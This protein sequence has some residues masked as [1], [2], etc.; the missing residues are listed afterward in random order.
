LLREHSRK[1]DI[2]SRWGGEE[3]VILL[4]DTNLHGALVV[5]EKI[6]KSVEDAV[7][8]LE[9]KQALKFTMSLGISQV[10]NQKDDDIEV[11]IHKADEALYEA[12]K[13]GRNRIHT[14]INNE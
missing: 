2:I 11:S 8:Y 9:D 10:D 12:K 13:N 5:A 7:I 4:V 3:F 1:S 6:R 14:Q